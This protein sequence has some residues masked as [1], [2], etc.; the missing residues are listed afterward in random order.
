MTTLPTRSQISK[1]AVCSLNAS[2][3]LNKATLQCNSFFRRKNRP[4]FNNNAI[5]PDCRQ[6]LFTKPVTPPFVSRVSAPFVFGKANVKWDAK[7]IFPNVN[8]HTVLQVN[9]DSEIV[10]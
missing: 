8:I 9:D 1:R 2:V 6:L 3:L 4:Q 5:Y 7:S 10:P